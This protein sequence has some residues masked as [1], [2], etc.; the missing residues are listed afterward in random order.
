MAWALV[1]AIKDQLSS[2][3]TSEFTSIANVKGEVQKL[4]SKLH[5]I[6][7]MLNDAEKRQ[8]K[9]EAMKLWID[10]LKDVSYQ[11]DDVLDEWNT[12]K[13]KADIE[14][15]E[16]AET[17]T[18]KRRKVLS[19]TNL[20]SSVSTV[21]QR[22]NIALLIKEIIGKLDEI[23]REGDMYQF[24]L[25]SSNEEVV[26]PPT[27]S[28]VD[29]SNILGRDKVKGVDVNAQGG[30]YG[31]ALQAALVIDLG[32][33]Y[34]RFKNPFHTARILLDHGADVTAYVAGSPHGDAL[35][36]AKA[37]WSHNERS[38]ANFMKLLKL[39]GWK[40]DKSGPDENGPQV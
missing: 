7:A 33:Y 21:S 3:I 15:E 30:K 10:E 2:L 20:N 34:M 18:A 26:R 1:S 39:K 36:A 11:V 27:A 31:T 28:H 19:L 9:E 13:I 16:E 17:S 12:A 25:S 38:L 32:P 14:K 8:V 37:L 4:E 24:V 40:E 23:D 6:Q 35:S 29:V 5:T 22:R